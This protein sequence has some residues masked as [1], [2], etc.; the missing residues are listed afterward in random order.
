M[1]FFEN[2]DMLLRTFWYVAIPAS[3]V[4]LVQTIMTFMGADAS[5][6][7]EADFDSNLD[8]GDAPFQLFS[9]RN[10]INFLLGFS[11]TGISLYQSIESKGLLI[12]ISLMVGVL[13]VALFFLVIRQIMKLA[14]DNSY[15][16]EE[17]L[18][19]MAEVYINIPAERNGK[20]KI[21][22]SVRGS[23]HEID[24]ISNTDA[25][26]SGSFVRIVKIENKNLVIVEK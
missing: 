4:F 21:Q 3:L 25:Y 18:N 26:P 23:V 1:E 24:A 19:K 12:I 7:V 15:K 6:G 17:T 10:L 5:E 11:W 13:F 2:M 16:I 20:G 9:L 8:S 14:E 22:I